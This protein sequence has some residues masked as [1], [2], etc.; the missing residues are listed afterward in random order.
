ME[1]CRK[2]KEGEDR[3]HRQQKQNKEREMRKSIAESNFYCSLRLMTA[4]P[5]ALYNL[6]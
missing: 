3:E 2:E 4:H 1:L 6:K 5:Q